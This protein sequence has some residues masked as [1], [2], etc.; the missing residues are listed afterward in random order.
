M[1]V[2]YNIILAEIQGQTLMV[3]NIYAPNV[4]HPIFLE[5]CLSDLLVQE[6]LQAA[7]HEA[8]ILCYFS[9]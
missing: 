1:L 8:R 6:G 9:G 5:V 7:M 4:D 3:A 2:L